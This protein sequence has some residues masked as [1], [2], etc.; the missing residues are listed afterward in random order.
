VSLQTILPTEKKFS[1]TR[2]GS[3]SYAGVRNGPAFSVGISISHVEVSFA[4]ILPFVSF[5]G[6]VTQ[7]CSFNYLSKRLQENYIVIDIINLRSH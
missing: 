5:L 4:D 3:D 6:N 2:N 7:I 1:H